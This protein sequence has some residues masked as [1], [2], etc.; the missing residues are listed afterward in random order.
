MDK[1]ILNLKNKIFNNINN[2]FNKNVLILSGGTVIAQILPIAVSPV[3]SR[4]YFPSDFGVLA[5]FVSITSIVSVIANGRYELAIM[6]PEKDED[7]IN[8]AA[9]GFLINIAISLLFLFLILLFKKPFL[10]LLK[11]ESLYFWIYF[12]P[13]TVFF[14]GLFTILNYANNRFK[15][16]KDISKATIMKGIAVSSIQLVMG[17]LKTG[18]SG[19]ISG[20]IIS[21][22]IANTKLFFNI[23]NTGLL[24][25]IKK[26]KIKEVAKRY[27]N[28]PKYSMWGALLNT[29]GY[30]ITNILIG[31]FFGSYYLGQYYMAFRIL[32]I[33]SVFIGSA[34]SQ[35]FFKQAT[36]E[37]QK[38]GKAINTFKS[39]IKKLLIIAFPIFLVI[40]LFVK[41]LFPIVFGKE[42]KD[43]GLYAMILAPFFCINFIS[44]SLTLTIIVY[45]KNKIEILYN[46]LLNIASI[47][48]II[49]F[50]NFFYLIIFLSF[51][52]SFIYLLLILFFYKL[53]SKI[54]KK[55]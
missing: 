54:K 14:I 44:S 31:A 43:A 10:K 53:S 2:E 11:A 26:D 38:T 33:P 24:K 48:G 35:V 23:K 7:A 21:Q 6:L 45:E 22:A 20:Q 46:L 25:E 34:I 27:S 42:W 52:L 37:V 49:I 41:P 12:A 3:L 5:L 30:Q 13:L 50:K 9:T 29:S 19:L 18:I 55:L 39:T 47:L 51:I 1:I 36:E 4:I 8:V 17:F 32:G 40:F 28:F 16:Y 15:L